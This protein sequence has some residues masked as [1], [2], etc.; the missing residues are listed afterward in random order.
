[1]QEYKNSSSQP[2]LIIIKSLSKGLPKKICSKLPTLLPLQVKINLPYLHSGGGLIDWSKIYVQAQ[3]TMRGDLRAYTQ[4]EWL[5]STGWI[6]LF[7]RFPYDALQLF[8]LD[9]FELAVTLI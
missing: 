5:R 1:M 6:P 2:I 4:V 9:M 7:L 8:M 3:S